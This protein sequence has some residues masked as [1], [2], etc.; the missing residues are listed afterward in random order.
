MFWKIPALLVMLG[1]VT[2]GTAVSQHSDDS[3]EAEHNEYQPP[4]LVLDAMGVKHG[5]VIAEVGAGRGRYAVLV[6]AAVGDKGKVYANDIDEAKLEYLNH[7]CE[8]DGIDNIETILG[9]VYHPLLPEGE[10][11]IVY[12]INTYHHLDDPVELMRNVIPALKTDGVLVIIEH[13]QAKFPT[14]GHSTPQNILFEQ[15]H[16]AGFELLRIETFL[17]RDNINIFRPAPKAETH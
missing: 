4:E 8:R 11:D 15:A 13:D 6:A 3:W 5:M 7:R 10:M 14:E 17:K 1:C 9:D 16:E 2:F 12:M